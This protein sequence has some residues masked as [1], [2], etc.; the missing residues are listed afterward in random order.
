MGGV[1]IKR[2]VGQLNRTTPTEDAVVCMVLSGTA[3]A[4]KIALGEHK[5]IFSTDALTDLGITAAN[6]ALAYQD[7]LDFYANAGN[8]AELNIMLV[9]DATSLT[10]IC[11]VTKDIGKKLLE[12][13]DGRGVIFIA[14]VKKPAG[15]T[16]TIT[17]GLDNDVNTAVTK[18]QAMAVAY[19]LENNPFI[20]VLPALGFATATIANLPLRSTF[21]NDYVALNTHCNKADGVVSM[22]WLAGW[23]A[24]CQVHQNIARVR[25]GKMSDSSFM[26]DGTPAKALKAQW[27]A[28][29]NKG[30]I[31]GI[32]RGAKS[33]FFYN[34][35]P[36]LTTIASDYSSIS[37]N[38]TINKAHRIGFN[39]LLEKL[40][41]DV[42]VD[43]STGK[44]EGSLISDWE[45]DVENEIRSQM[46]IAGANKKAEISGVKCTIDPNSDIVNDKI[47]ATIDI[48]RKGQ[49]KTINVRIGYVV[50]I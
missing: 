47:E 14:N 18:L 38:R 21:S 15:Y 24:K 8:G 23:L 45:S 9:S 50:S 35:D 49:A 46:A 32:K 28:L 41:D 11:D 20:G 3:V 29:L 17:D 26:P 31:V 42:D 30:L 7:V 13:V 25:F 5:Q 43:A 37:W 33:G 12:A 16:P 19:G 2:A 27:E 39:I 48:V 4:G 10:D 44:I 22:G 1:I 34:D 40:N 36:C 6:N